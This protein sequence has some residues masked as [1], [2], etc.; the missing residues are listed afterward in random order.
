MRWLGRL[1]STRPGEIDTAEE[2]SEPPVDLAP[3][4]RK[5]GEEYLPYLRANATVYVANNSTTG[6]HL[7][8]LDW[9]V[10]TAPYRVY[11]LV[12]LQK[13]FQALSKADQQRCRELIGDTGTDVL[14][15]L[16]DC[17][18]EFRDVSAAQ[19]Y[20]P[21]EGASL[22][23]LWQKEKTFLE[24]WATDYVVAKPTKAVVETKRAGT[25]WLPIY[26][27]KYRAKK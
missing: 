6:Y 3:L 1:R 22:G 9:E 8:G 4:M 15:N 12:H 26:F 19:S 18:E 25:D 16:I 24:N 13:R 23:R 27:R 7:D 5:M 11:C 14:E 10:T 20:R 17:P 2:L 21:H